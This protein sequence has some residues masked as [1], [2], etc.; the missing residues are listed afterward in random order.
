MWLKLELSRS[1]AI[2]GMK[3]DSYCLSNYDVDL[4]NR[5][6]SHTLF[7]IEFISFIIVNPEDAYWGRPLATNRIS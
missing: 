5:A 1:T 2:G 4:N 3:H 6:I 7:L